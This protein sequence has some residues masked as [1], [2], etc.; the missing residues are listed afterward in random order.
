MSLYEDDMIKH[1]IDQFI[2]TLLRF[3]TLAFNRRAKH[4]WWNGWLDVGIF[5]YIY[6]YCELYTYRQRQSLSNQVH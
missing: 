1:F 5:D 4:M 6:V 2:L 3:S